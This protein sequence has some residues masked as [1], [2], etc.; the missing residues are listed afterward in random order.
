MNRPRRFAALAALSVGLAVLVVVYHGELAGWIAG[1]RD[2]TGLGDEPVAFYTCPMDPS[3]ESDHPGPCPICG[4]A[5][6]P[7]SKEDRT[8]GV[9]R[10]AAAARARLGVVV[11][12]VE[13]RPLFRRVVAAGEVVASPPAAAG[14]ASIAA[15]VYRG[16]AHEVRPGQPVNASA[17]ELPLQ[18]FPGT[19]EPPRATDPPG[20]LR[21]VVDDP[22]HMLHPGMRVEA[23]LEVALSPRLVVP[24]EAVLY[25]GPRRIVFVEHGSGRFEPKTP[26][27]GITATGLVEV[28]DGLAAGEQVAVKGTF[29]LAAQ[30]RLRSDSSLWGELAK[31]APVK[32]TRPA[33]ASA[34]PEGSGW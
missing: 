9:V 1:D 29:L 22:G 3:V 7:V 21:L 15:R 12:P 2:A 28:L 31:P 13:T 6:T 19:V 11:A 24:A 27:L 5:L 20:A 25:A 34:T 16:D 8:S 23:Q 10:V 26:K 18:A 14:R 32:P 17:P 30:S 33:P 4:M